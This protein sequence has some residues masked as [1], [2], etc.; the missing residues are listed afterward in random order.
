MKTRKYYLAYG[1]NTN[2]EQMSNRCPAAK[3][4]GIVQLTDHKLAFK[5]FC[6]A[7]K[8]I[9]AAMSCVLWSI[10][11]DCE[12]ALDILE[13]YPDFYRK[14]EVTVNFCNRPITAMIYYMT[15]MYEKSQPSNSYL[16][17]VAE[18]YL[19][20][21]INLDQIYNALDEVV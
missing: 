20:H 11:E 12:Q 17:A 16:K 19:R 2:I 9:G 3:S 1:M 18:G 7:E 8:K 6:D 21:H 5:T 4:L 15:D 10:T 14:K 13:G